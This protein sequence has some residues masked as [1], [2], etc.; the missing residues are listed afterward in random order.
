MSDSAGFGG[1]AGERQLEALGRVASVIAHELTNLLQILGSS[2]DRLALGHDSDDATVKTVR[3][4]LERGT[5][6]ARQLQTFAQT[7]PPRLLLREI[8]QLIAGWMPDFEEALGPDRRLELRLRHSG[9]ALV[10]VEQLE[11][12][13]INLI[14]NA[15]D[16]SA[17]GGSVVI[18]LARI[19]PAAGGGPGSVGG[20]RIAV[21]DHGEGMTDE[22]ARQAVAPF[23]TTRAPGKGM[24]LGLTIARMVAEAHGGSLDVDTAFGRGTTVSMYLPSA[25]AETRGGNGG[26]HGH[27]HGV[28]SGGANGPGVGATPSALGPAGSLAGTPSVSAPSLSREATPHLVVPRIE[29]DPSSLHHA[30]P[31]ELGPSLLD[32]P[33]ELPTAAPPLP[34]SSMLTHPVVPHGPPSQ[35]IAVP[36][37]SQQA[38]PVRPSPFAHAS[39]SGCVLVVDD[40]EAI[41]DY[42]RIILTADRYDVH[43]VTS[44]HQALDRFAQD[45]Q[46]YDAVLLDMML[47]DGSGID[48]YRKFR[49]LRPDLAVVVCTGFSD[50]DSLAPIRADGHDILFKP[51]PRGDVLKAVAHAVSRRRASGG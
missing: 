39:A 15:R 19:E 32:R 23:F 44:A 11:T 41:A 36:P 17:P 47:R 10:D 43:V 34:S 22:V 45:P 49:Q 8:H 21:I 38:L 48:L 29:P 42:F 13:L 31:H 51:C 40:E 6:L 9:A 3:G 2:V 28:A 46:R 50:N 1:F 35:P 24:G 16:A 5:R 37:P 30:A 25:T 20:C 33:R 27:G 26:S 12:A 18:E 4:S 14:S 7:T